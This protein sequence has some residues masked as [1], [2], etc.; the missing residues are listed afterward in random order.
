M[1]QYTNQETK[2]L[3]CNDELLQIL[4]NADKLGSNIPPTLLYNEGWMLRFILQEIKNKKIIHSD[5][6]FQDND[7]DWFSEALLPSPFL[8]RTRGDKLS[9][10]WTHADGVVGKF[11]IG[12][13][14]KGDLTLKDS[15]DFFYVTEAKMYSKLSAGTTNAKTYNQAARYVACIAKLISD[16]DTIQ[17]DN[18]KK[19]GFYVLLPEEQIKKKQTFTDF[20]EKNHIKSTIKDRMDSYSNDVAKKEKIFN[21]INVNLDNFIDKL[22]VKLIK[23]EDLVDECGNSNIKDFY[24][25]CKTYNKKKNNIKA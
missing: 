16:N 14:A 24:E 1:K 22:E 13:N 15:C 23:W 3:F 5:L 21:W 12:K 8:A 18:F 6:S 17:I 2:D 7:V 25:K 19:L 20:T 11:K 10:T 4:K 9:E